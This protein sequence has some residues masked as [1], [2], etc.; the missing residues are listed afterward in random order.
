[1]AFFIEKRFGPVHVCYTT[2]IV[3]R[4]ATRPRAYGLW[5]QLVR[6]HDISAWEAHIAYFRLRLLLFLWTTFQPHTVNLTCK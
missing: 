3:K 2:L 6:A 5:G 1:M 4:P